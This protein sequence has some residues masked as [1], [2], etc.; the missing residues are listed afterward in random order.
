MKKED[1]PMI[2]KNQQS[3][4]NFLYGAVIA[5]TALSKSRLAATT[6]NDIRSKVVNS[7][8]FRKRINII[9]K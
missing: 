3:F 9:F 1:K 7:N 5:L 2:I 8:V 6:L 4:T